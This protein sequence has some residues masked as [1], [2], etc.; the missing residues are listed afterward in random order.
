MDDRKIWD[1]AGENKMFGVRLPIAVQR[2]IGG[3]IG[4][5]PGHLENAAEAVRQAIYAAYWSHFLRWW[6]RDYTTEDLMKLGY[7]DLVE[8]STNADEI[9]DEADSVVQFLESSAKAASDAAK[10]GREQ[11]ARVKIEFETKVVTGTAILRDLKAGTISDAQADEQM[12]S[13]VG[14]SLNAFRKFIASAK[15]IPLIRID[16]NG[17]A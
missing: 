13:K 5:A 14:L 11:V 2:M 3:F 12:L 4:L 9:L 15:S 1:D 16:E 6:L 7:R 17:R 10:E 8:A